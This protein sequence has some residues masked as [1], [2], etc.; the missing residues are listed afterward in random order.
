MAKFKV[1]IGTHLEDGKSYGKDQIVKS[2]KDL[3]TLF[4]G[5][6]IKLEYA[7]VEPEPEA[8]APAPPAAAKHTTMPAAAKP[9]AKPASKGR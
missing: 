3:T 6:F 4:P 7:P 5:K 9:A 8:P 1:V 2:E